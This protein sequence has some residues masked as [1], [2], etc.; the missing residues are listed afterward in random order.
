[1]LPNSWTKQTTFTRHDLKSEDPIV[2]V[3]AIQY[4]SRQK[5]QTVI[6]EL[7]KLLRDDD[8]TIRDQAYAAL[9]HLSDGKQ[10]PGD[11][12]EFRAYD[13]PDIRNQAIAAWEAAYGIA[14]SR[15]P[16]EKPQ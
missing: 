4:L 14:P 16:A 13:S 2:K 11:H 15:A 5:N 7:I 1:M 10:I 8:P 9:E 12:P 3:R 6:P